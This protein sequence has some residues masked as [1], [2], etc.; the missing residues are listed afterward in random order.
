MV[1]HLNNPAP[2][3]GLAQPAFRALLDLAR[4]PQVHVK[5]SGFHH[6][7]RERYPYPDGLPFAEAAVRAFGAGRCM[8][9]SDFPHV[10]AGCGYVRSR[11]LLPREAAF[12]SKE[13]LGL[14]MGGTAERLWFG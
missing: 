4:C 10:L 11:H 1:D 2:A 14:V 3:A 8:W 7:C 13:E 12:L 6:W 5:L 9:G